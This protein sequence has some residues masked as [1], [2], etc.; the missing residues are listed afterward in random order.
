VE[1]GGKL[2]GR[3]GRRERK[4]WGIGDWGRKIWEKR[5]GIEEAR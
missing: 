2:G 5:E 4:K 1:R 3:E